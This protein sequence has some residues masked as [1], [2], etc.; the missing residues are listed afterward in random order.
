MY[1][2]HVFIITGKCSSVQFLTEESI[3]ELIEECKEGNSYSKLIR[4]VG[5]TFNNPES[6]SVSFLKQKKETNQ[7]QKQEDAKS[8]YD[9]DKDVDEKEE[10][11]DIQSKHKLNQTAIERLNLSE[12]DV[13]VDIESVRRA[14]GM[15]MSIPDLPFIPALINALTYLAKGILIDLKFNSLIL[16]QNPQLLN[17]FVIVMELPCLSSPEFIENAYPDFC[18]AVSKLPL[19]GQCKLAKVWSKFGHNWLLEK[20]H[21]LHQLITV[22]IVNNEGRWGRSYHINDDDGIAGAAKMMK[23][24]YYASIYGGER[25]SE[26][27]IA[28]EKAVN[29]VDENLQDMLQLQG[30][31]GH[32]EPKESRLQKDDPFA[33]QMN[34]HSVDCRNPLVPYEE[35]INE[36]LN[37]Y[38][39]VETD[40]KYKDDTEDNKI[41]FMNHSY[42]LTTS[43]KFTLMYFDNRIRMLNERR[44]SIIQTFVHGLPPIPFLRLQVRRDHLIDDALVAVG[45]ESN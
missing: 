11:I 3:K 23:I 26:Q 17:V 41:S 28:E 18:K 9:E 25:D 39:D 4:L 15:L 21:S 6:L 32:S 30:A 36:L 44:T 2:I 45:I 31:V 13:S 14:F 27:I 19:Q 16:K 10:F 38:L 24:L 34:V 12:D 8:K 1:N 7:K 33:Q 43:S 29:E 35:F 40:Y 37:E 22:K 5:S 20:V 42:I